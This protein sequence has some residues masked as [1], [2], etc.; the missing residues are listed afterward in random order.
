[1]LQMGSFD[2][3]RDWLIGMLVAGVIGL[4]SLVRKLDVGEINR[5]L[6][7]IEKEL[8]ELREDRGR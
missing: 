2:S 1:M 6:D 3:F 5:R 8:D 4:L 7:R